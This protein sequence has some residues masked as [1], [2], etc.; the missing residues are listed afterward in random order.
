[1]IKIP[2][3][4]FAC[5]I[6]GGEH[7]ARLKPA[8]ETVFNVKYFADLYKIHQNDI[9]Q[10]LSDKLATELSYYVNGVHDDLAVI[11]FDRLVSLDAQGIVCTPAISKK[12][13]KAVSFGTIAYRF[14]QSEETLEVTISVMDKENRNVDCPFLAFTAEKFAGGI[15]IDIPTDVKA[16]IM[17]MHGKSEQDM[18]KTAWYWVKFICAFETVFTY[19]CIRFKAFS[20]D[21]MLEKND[22]QLNPNFIKVNRLTLEGENEGMS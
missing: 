2:I 6:A 14:S 16:P 9:P 21:A 4:P 8:N 20:Y 17:L 18:E 15:G 22:I 10:L 13:N 7:H 11:M 19:Q 3:L 1:M 12:D 5:S